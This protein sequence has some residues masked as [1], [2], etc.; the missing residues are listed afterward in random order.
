MNR[1]DI[2]TSRKIHTILAL[3]R[4]KGV[5]PVQVL[6]KGGFL[7][8]EDSVRRETAGILEAMIEII[9]ALPDV[10]DMSSLKTPMDMKILII[11]RLK[12]LHR[13]ISTAQ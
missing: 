12:E 5:D 10:S 9:E 7:R 8:Y 6:D 3:C 2:E 11:E 4:S 1:V 13:A